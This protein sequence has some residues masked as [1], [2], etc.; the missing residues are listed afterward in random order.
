LRPD[1]RLIVGRR[2]CSALATGLAWQVEALA[3]GLDAAEID[4]HPAVTPVLC[5]ID[6]DWPLFGAPDSFGGVR[7]EGPKSLRKAVTAAAI[8]DAPSIERLANAL[9]AGLPAK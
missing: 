8:L 2:D 5:F 3:T 1:Y 6:G 7:L 4:P 9:A